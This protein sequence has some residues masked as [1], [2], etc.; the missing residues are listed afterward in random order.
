MKKTPL[1][2]YNL[3]P[4]LGGYFHLWIEHINRA[5]KMGFNTIYIN[6][7]Q[8]PGFSGSCYSIKDYFKID[9]DRYYD[10]E[11][12]GTPEE[13]FQEVVDYIHEK[14]MKIIIDLVINHTAI[15]SPLIHEHPDWY[16]LK[17]DGSVENPKAL[18]GERVVAVWG[19]LAEIDN[20]NSTDKNALWKY[21]KKLVDYF[22]DFGIDGFRCDAAY[23]VPV[24]LWKELIQHA[25]RKRKDALFLAETLGCPFNEVLELAQCGFDYVFNSSKYWD[26]NADWCLEQ[27]DKLVG[28][29]RTISFPES[30]DTI[31]LMD[32]LQGNIEGIKQRY[33]FEVFF[34]SG[35][36]I[37]MGFEF[38]FKNKLDV[39]H[40]SPFNWEK[41]EIDLT[42]FIA[43]AN[44]L[45]YDYEIFREESP[46]E[47]IPSNNHNV[48]LL[49]K[50]WP[51]KHEIALLIL[52][53]DIQNYQYIYID[54]FDGIFEKNEKI[55]DIS[56]EYARDFVPVPFDYH[57][58]PGQVI[59]LYQKY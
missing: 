13:Q 24:D 15:D 16:K 18:E 20:R 30:H 46:I 42:H 3:F 55:R 32:E 52:N 35:V 58:R 53:K 36:M 28:K 33:I 51:E 14:K 41:T 40:T 22:L 4:R 12:D 44:R 50:S 11:H 39:V 49:K 57:L 48:L 21:W 43:K 26:Y 23:Q 45:K 29:T 8:Y 6:P 25:R 37:P 56:I 59:L 17:E 9:E 31:R 47:K 38:G 19:D 54:N 2:I 1:L 5:H 34:S 10:P 27:Y 7:I